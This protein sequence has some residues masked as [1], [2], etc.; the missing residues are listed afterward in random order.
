MSIEK[1]ISIPLV[2]LFPMAFFFH[3]YY[4]HNFGESNVFLVYSMKLCFIFLF[5]LYFR[6]Q[7]AKLL[8][9]EKFIFFVFIFVIVFSLLSSLI[10]SYLISFKY[11]F[12]DIFGLLIVAFYYI[13]IRSYIEYSP[14][15]YEKLL[16][17]ISN[18]TM[19]VSLVV[20]FYFFY[21]GGA[22]VSI[23]PEMH[24]GLSLVLL[25]FLYSSK[26]SKMDYIRLLIVI[27][28]GF[29]SLQR[30][31]II[32]VFITLFFWLFDLSKP[33]IWKILTMLLCLVMALALKDQALL[34]LE[35]RNMVFTFGGEGLLS[36]QDGSANQRF[37]EA[38]LVFD[39]IKNSDYSAFSWLFGLGFG[40]EFVN[41]SNSLPHKGEFIHHVHVTPVLL[42]LRNGFL[43][44]LLF[45]IPLLLSCKLIFSNRRG[46][47]AFIILF[48]T[49]IAMLFDQYVYWG[50]AYAISLALCFYNLK[51]T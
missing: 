46:K 9:A 38:K 15:N 42:I 17:I 30:I 43:G 27:T 48:C 1:I 6:I 49:Y 51:T 23:P 41:S 44:L 34:L 5:L 37:V 16:K 4:W 19:T 40:A 47:I 36:F 3:G 50:A 8:F 45:L 28:A 7:L 14:N 18:S 2:V 26:R 10:N 11:F 13:I 33:R 29:L 22:K 20:I 32:I 24:M 12:F 31:Y 35:S 21:S 39:T 25:L